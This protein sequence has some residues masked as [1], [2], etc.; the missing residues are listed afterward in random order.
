MWSVKEQVKQT[1]G[2]TGTGKEK[3]QGHT[4]LEAKL[5][6]VPR[7]ERSGVPE[8]PVGQTYV[9]EASAEREREGDGWRS[10]DGGRGIDGGGGGEGQRGMDG[11]GGR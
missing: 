3:H 10:G 2:P 5:R 6:R 9:T 7:T 11:G 8:A 1:I 4:L